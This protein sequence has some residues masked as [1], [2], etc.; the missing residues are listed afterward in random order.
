MI[1]TSTQPWRALIPILLVVGIGITVWGSFRLANTA[2]DIWA[3]SARTFAASKRARLD[4]TW[5]HTVDQLA[6]LA[7]Y[8]SLAR[9]DETSFVNAVTRLTGTV[10]S[11][12]ALIYSHGG[13]VNTY[14][15]R[16]LPT[17]TTALLAQITA[18]LNQTAATNRTDL[19]VLQ[20]A[21]A[22]KALRAMGFASNNIIAAAL[23][24]AQTQGN[25]MVVFIDVPA[26]LE[27]G[28]DNADRTIGS[29]GVNVRVIGEGDAELATG[30]VVLGQNVEASFTHDL[31][32][33][34]GN[35]EWRL[36]WL[37]GWQALGGPNWV[38]AWMV[39]G[40]GVLMTLG[41][42][43]LLWAQQNISRRIR[44]EVVDR[45]NQLEQASRKFRLITDNAYDLITIVSIDGVFE[46]VNSAYHRVLGYARED[47]RGQN[48]TTIVHP[49]DI[50]LLQQGL[51]DVASGR[52]VAELTFRARHKNGSWLF[53]EAVAK[54]LHD[55]DWSV[56]SLVIHCRDVTS[57]KQYADELSRSEQRFR[58]FADSSADWL[59][60]VNERMEFTYISPGVQNTL[61]HTPQELVGKSL[62]DMIFS[63]N[64]DATRELVEQR[65]QRRQPFRDVK[66]WTRAK[67]AER[68][69]LRMSGVP[70]FDDR[71]NFMGYRGAATNVTASELDREHMQKLATTDHLTNLL[72]RTRFD[73]EL[74]R[75]VTLAK[76]HKTKG[77]LLFIDLDR[78]KE[79]NDTHGH[80]AGDMI[81]KAV[82]DL[83][84]K[85]LRSTDIISRA[86]GDEFR[87]IMHKIDVP[88][89]TEKVNKIIERMNRLKVEYKGAKL[90]VT[91]SIGMVVY[92]QEEKNTQDL[93]M[94]ADLAMYRAKAMGRNRM[95]VDSDE[96]TE[97]TKVSVR[98]QLKWV[99]HLRTALETG[100]F[101]MHYQPIVPL[102]KRPRPLVEALLR[103]RDE[104]GKIGS[105]ALY[106]DSAEHFGLI[107]ELDLKVIERC[108]S[109]QAELQ[110]EN[111]NIDMSINLSS[112]SIGD[113]EVIETLQLMTRKYKFDPAH[114]MFEVTETVALHD[115][116]SLR[117]ISTIRAFI[118]ELRR[119][120]F[121]FALDDFG[122][123]FSS[124]SYMRALDLD[125]VKIDGSF[126]K[127]LETS[128]SDTLFVRSMIDLASGLGIKTIAEFVENEKITRLL[129]DMGVDYAQGWHTGKPQADIREIYKNYLGK[130]M[131]DYMQPPAK[132]VPIKTENKS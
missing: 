10:P 79:V 59:W 104:S 57:R 12:K 64:R 1:P 23:P 62:F 42:C 54:G 7:H 72:N 108:I 2:T 90:Q 84:K 74:E 89:A 105:P 116:S 25:V 48:I 73:E 112:R 75:S 37:F 51:T 66:Y 47:L 93:I 117:D 83:L 30:R 82:A 122:S 86:G 109:T 77:A 9:D 16:T 33:H 129:A 91:M 4:L 49:K 41:F 113:P 26:F 115:P 101:E 81:L 98:E 114:I 110:L 78:F 58:D 63:K 53:L 125:V 94:T 123:G 44:E 99:E 6:D 24:L 11:M 35:V 70:V 3:E 31:K 119:L 56:T 102:Q 22:D 68:V 97:E 85:S 120:G 95:Y 61:A 13:V 100:S 130:T 121:R 50:T 106:I 88:R 8:V 34:W 32:V 36:R 76:R 87:V 128:K 96:K 40:M 21:L 14:P 107:Q 45:T 118:T 65:V 38:P 131:E 18:Q 29:A 39:F 28:F 80:E 71:Q 15:A 111:I 103:I 52:N 67:S 69:C 124:F 5:R 60:E 126:V 55:Q 19:N 46:Y 132:V 43:W 27:Q 92:P 17:D 20:G 127:E